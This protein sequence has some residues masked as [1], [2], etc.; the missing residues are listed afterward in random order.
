MQI[1]LATY[2][3][4]DTWDDYVLKHANGT[5]YQLFAWRMAV[6]EAYAFK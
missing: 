2:A 5:A 1:R 3:D 6:E 4:K